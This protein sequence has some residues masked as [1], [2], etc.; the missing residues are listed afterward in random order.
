MRKFAII[1]VLAA[2]VLLCACADGEVVS[3]TPPSEDVPP[4]V[5]VPTTAPPVSEEPVAEPYTIYEINWSMTGGTGGGADFPIIVGDTEEIEMLNAYFFERAQ[6][7]WGEEGRSTEAKAYYNKNGVISF[8]Y[9]GK[10]DYYTGYFMDDDSEYLYTEISYKTL[11]VN[12]ISGTRVTLDEL[13]TVARDEY[14]ARLFEYDSMLFDVENFYLDSDELVLFFA[15]NTVTD[16]GEWYFHNVP[17]SEVSD[18]LADWV[19]YD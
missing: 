1:A 9:T 11:T 2:L 16:D 5:G 17:Y 15:P 18:I 6:S 3:A 4:S 10:R 14:L 8:L 13:F 7:D 19:I 12:V